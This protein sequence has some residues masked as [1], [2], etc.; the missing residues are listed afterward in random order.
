MKGNLIARRLH[1]VVIRGVKGK[2]MVCEICGTS[3]RVGKMILPGEVSFD[4]C[5]WCH[6]DE[7]RVVKWLMR[8]L[9]SALE[10][11]PEYKRLPDGRW[12]SV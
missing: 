1:G 5:V 3:L 12:V 7:D 6:E 11:S 8:E 2:K 4:L 10:S 9:T